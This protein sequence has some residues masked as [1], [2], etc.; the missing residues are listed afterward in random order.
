MSFCLLA[1]GSIPVTDVLTIVTLAS[2]FTSVPTSLVDEAL[3]H[4][5]LVSSPGR[6][7]YP[8]GGVP[9]VDSPPKK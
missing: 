9:I 8:T 3:S 6:V 2:H 4:K 5:L 7:T 1:Y